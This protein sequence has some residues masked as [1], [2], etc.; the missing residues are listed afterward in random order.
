MAR[1]MN[2]EDRRAEHDLAMRGDDPGMRR[3]GRS[4]RRIDRSRDEQA[5][6]SG[7][8]PE[9]DDEAE[10]PATPIGFFHDEDADD[11]AGSWRGGRHLL[12]QARGRR[13]RREPRR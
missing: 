1:K 2:D 9:E 13:E 12:R 10:E 8:L 4:R 3:D 6:Y 5:F 11:G 7:T